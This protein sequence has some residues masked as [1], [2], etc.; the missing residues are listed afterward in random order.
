MLEKTLSGK[1]TYGAYKFSISA[2]TNYHKLVIL[3][4]IYIAS[5]VV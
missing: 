1:Q 3:T 4:Q 2:V 5:I